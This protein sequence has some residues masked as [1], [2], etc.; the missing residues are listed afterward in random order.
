[1]QRITFKN[2]L[3]ISACLAFETFGA[4]WAELA[5]EKEVLH[6]GIVFKADFT[7]Y[8]DLELEPL[9]V[10]NLQKELNI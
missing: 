8:G 9:S 6:G 5:N 7:P 3:I 1:M 2:T 4:Q 10:V